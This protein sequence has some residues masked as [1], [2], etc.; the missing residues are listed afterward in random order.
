M[1]KFKVIFTDS[2]TGHDL[3]VNFVVEGYKMSEVAARLELRE[4]SFRLIEDV[5][6]SHPSG[7]T[8]NPWETIPLRAFSR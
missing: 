8:F 4:A 1:K 7:F 2:K 3:Y 5:T 6:I